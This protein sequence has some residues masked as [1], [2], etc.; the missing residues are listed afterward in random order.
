MFEDTLRYSVVGRLK[1][2]SKDEITTESFLIKFHSF[3]D[4]MGT[5]GIYPYL[6]PQYG[7]ADLS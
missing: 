7:I 4:S 5:H 6:Y 2:Q 3:L 1:P